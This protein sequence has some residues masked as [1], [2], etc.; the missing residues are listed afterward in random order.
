MNRTSI[1]TTLACTFALGLAACESEGPGE[2]IGEEV[3][4]AADT[5]RHG[6]ESTANQVDDAVD[7][8]REGARETAEEMQ[9]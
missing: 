9:Q 2:R 3:D 8:M 5:I 7:E 1:V 4:E 6:E